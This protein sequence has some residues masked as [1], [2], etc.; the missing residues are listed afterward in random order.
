DWRVRRENRRAPHTTSGRLELSSLD[1]KFFV[2]LKEPLVLKYVQEFAVFLVSLEK[3]ASD[4]I[5]AQSHNIFV[6]LVVPQ[7]GRGVS[8]LREIDRLRIIEIHDRFVDEFVGAVDLRVGAVHSR[9]ALLLSLGKARVQSIG[10]HAR[11]V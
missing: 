6:M 7:S 11:T 3:I 8:G 5:M 10:H 1:D 9:P 2:L 4:Q